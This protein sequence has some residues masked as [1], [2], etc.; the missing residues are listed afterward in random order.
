MGLALQQLT[1][2]TKGSTFGGGLQYAVHSSEV[3]WQDY[4]GEGVAA[5][6]QGRQIEAVRI[7]LTG[8]LSR[9]FDVYY[10]AHVSS[11]GWMGWTKNGS[12]AGTASLGNR[13]EALQVL[14]V[15]QG[16]P[17]PGSMATPF[18]DVWYTAKVSAL[19]QNPELPTGCE[20]VAL[21]IVLRSMG[22]NVAKTE[23]ADFYLPISSWDY[24]NSF[25]GDPRSFGG[26]YN[27]AMPPAIVTTAN[28]YLSARGASQRAHDISGTSFNGLYS[29]IDQGYP[30]LVWTTISMGNPLFYNTSLFGYRF[31]ENEHCV[32]MYGYDQASNSVLVS[33]PLGGIVRRNASIFGDIYQRCGSM[34]M[35]IK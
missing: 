15:P 34:S 10:R 19:F 23:L 3:G 32:V 13:L 35:V 7:R 22:Y 24:V 33:D 27:A 18:R 25:A 26:N 14:I 31:Y 20:S 5:G 6:V 4:V 21:A 12:N 2:S 8:D 1:M 11:F 28:R 29:H 17:A 16:S 30:V 9:Y